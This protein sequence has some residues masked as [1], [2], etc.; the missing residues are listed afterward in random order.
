M[1]MRCWVAG[2]GCCVLDRLTVK[3][4][5]RFQKSLNSR[6]YWARSGHEKIKTQTL[7]IQYT[8]KHPSHWPNMRHMPIYEDQ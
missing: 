6:K 4:E 5:L 2:I 3:I 8:I 1:A 7:T